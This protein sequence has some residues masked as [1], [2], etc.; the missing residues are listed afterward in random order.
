MTVHIRPIEFARPPN[1]SD[2]TRELAEWAMG[3]W[4]SVNET[5]PECP[6]KDWALTVLLAEVQRLIFSDGARVH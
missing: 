6:Q 3:C 5:C 4:D 1:L 2:R